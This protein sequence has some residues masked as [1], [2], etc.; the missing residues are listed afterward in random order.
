MFERLARRVGKWFLHTYL[1]QT[2]AI[3]SKSPNGVE[4]FLNPCISSSITAF[5]RIQRVCYYPYDQLYPLS[6]LDFASQRKACFN[7]L[8]NIPKYFISCK[9]NVVTTPVRKRTLKV[10]IGWNQS[11]KVQ[12]NF[13][14]VCV[15]EGGC[16][17]CCWCWYCCCWCFTTQIGSVYFIFPTSLMESWTLS[18]EAVGLENLKG[19]FIVGNCPSSLNWPLMLGKVIRKKTFYSP[20]CFCLSMTSLQ[21]AKLLLIFFLNLSALTVYNLSLA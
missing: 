18:G 5:S 19:F 21:A 13:A 7:I 14:S 17:C 12:L 16:C 3:L 1:N 15:W 11:E 4:F 20:D 6:C 8:P 10:E 9:R 2:K